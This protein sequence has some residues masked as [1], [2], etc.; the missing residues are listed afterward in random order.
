MHEKGLPGRPDIVFP[1]R[2]LAVFIDGCFWHGCPK[3]YRRPHSRRKYWDNKVAKNKKRDKLQRIQLKK[4]GW[5][6]F[7]IW[8]HEIALSTKHVCAAISKKVTSLI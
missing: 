1:D 4:Q 7:Q 2:N 6:I 8:E 5:K 3:C